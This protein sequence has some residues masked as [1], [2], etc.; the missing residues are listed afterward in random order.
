MAEFSRRNLTINLKRK[1]KCHVTLC[2]RIDLRLSPPADAAG[3]RRRVVVGRL[4]VVVNT[5]Q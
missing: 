1:N 4:A 5:V 3:R 2:E